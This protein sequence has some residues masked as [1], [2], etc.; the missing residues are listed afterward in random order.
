MKKIKRKKEEEEE[1]KAKRIEADGP[2]HS[3]IPLFQ[4]HTIV[5]THLCGIN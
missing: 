3:S 4:A 1:A 2:F 5:I